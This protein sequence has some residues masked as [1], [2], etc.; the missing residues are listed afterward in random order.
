MEPWNMSV[1]GTV[2]GGSANITVNPNG[3]LSSGWQ[4]APYAGMMTAMYFTNDPF[5]S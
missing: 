5:P 4:D 1:G 3:T 2:S